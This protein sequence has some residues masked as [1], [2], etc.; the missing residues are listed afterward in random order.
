MKKKLLAL[1]LVASMAASLAACG[2]VGNT[3]ET[4]K[5][6]V[7]PPVETAAPDEVGEEQE[8]EIVS[9]EETPPAEERLSDEE[10]FQQF[11]NGEAE[12]ALEAKPNYSLSYA[13]TV[14][15]YETWEQSYTFDSQ[16]TISLAQLRTA[17]EESPGLRISNMEIDYAITETVSGKPML[18]VRHQNLGI[19]DPSDDS[20]AVFFFAVN[21]GV[22]TMTYAYD[23]W[24]RSYVTLCEN[25]IFPAHG[26]SG[27]GDS[28]DWCSYIDETGHYKLLYDL[29]TL[30]G[31][32]VAMYDWEDFGMDTDW[33]NNCVC[34]LLTTQEGS[35][36][37][38]EVNGPVDSGKLD[39]FVA[40]L[41][42][43]GMSPIDDVGE[44][45][46]T[47]YATSG[48]PEGDLTP[49]DSWTH[50]NMG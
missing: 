43:M 26:S 29:R 14:M 18:A 15:D 34:Y 48:I 46:S 50:L 38:L 42:S 9:V 5:N 8:A 35:F 40:Y 27:A 25:L 2:G 47:A 11:L 4:E 39:T 24:A 33:S 19:Y 36:Y 12:A 17:V 16:E 13:C 21:D 45:I 3:A 10:I 6:A 41:E 22:L 44:A 31:P 7:E 23:T 20:N 32:W 1:L 28:S 30:G 49:F 37:A